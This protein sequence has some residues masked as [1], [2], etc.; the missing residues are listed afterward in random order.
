[1]SREER[2]WRHDEERG[3]SVGIDG[4]EGTWRRGETR[5]GETSL[6]LRLHVRS[7]WESA[8]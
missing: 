6:V 8:D 1:M 7:R 4:E 5:A 2:T 3:G